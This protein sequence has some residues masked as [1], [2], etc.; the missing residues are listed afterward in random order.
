M[1][2]PWQRD[3]L[4]KT[5]T[6]GEML[7]I[8]KILFPTDFSECAEDAYSVALGMADR[9]GAELHIV[10]VAVQKWQGSATTLL[11]F[12]IQEDEIQEPLAPPPEKRLEE[13]IVAPGVVT[14][15]TCVQA[16]TVADG[17]VDY[18]R[19]HDVDLIVMATHGRCGMER[20]LMGSVTEDVVRHSSCP[21]FTVHSGF[22]DESEGQ[23]RRILVPV[24]FSEHSNVSLVYANELAGMYDA[25]IDV[26][27]ILEET[28]LPHVYG[29][30]PVAV[31]LPE[32]EDRT[33]QALEELTQT[34][35]DTGGDGVPVELH[36]VVG[37][38]SSDIIQFA[39]Q[40]QTDLIIIG[41]HGRSRLMRL[42]LGS[43]TEKVVRH[44][45]CPVFTVKSFGKSLIRS[46]S[47]ASDSVRE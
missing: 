2:Q 3:L 26:L 38:P 12:P 39:T 23:F 27:H 28:V 8:N 44:A 19:Q 45:P 18:E 7:Q 9:F 4:T 10:N 46:F 42:L 24:D 36:V 33:E 14:K 13:R 16:E 22:T 37:H 40:H 6:E 15:S 21:V 41:T 43:V 35:K 1:R 17:I 5:D 29:I 25:S 11:D 32:L 31:A 20:L 34:V 30:E 47:V